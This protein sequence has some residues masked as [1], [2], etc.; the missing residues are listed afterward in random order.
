MQPRLVPYQIPSNFSGIR[1]AE[2]SPSLATFNTSERLEKF[3]EYAFYA[4]A[5]ARGVRTIDRSRRSARPGPRQGARRRGRHQSV[6]RGSRTADDPDSS[7]DLLDRQGGA[8]RPRLVE[9]RSSLLARQ[10]VAVGGERRAAQA[11]AR[12]RA[13]ACVGDAPPARARRSVEGA[14]DAR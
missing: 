5:T 6:A 8:D 4:D 14:T 2:V 13:P 12:P 1:V 3:V 11:G 7:A 10:A 9:V